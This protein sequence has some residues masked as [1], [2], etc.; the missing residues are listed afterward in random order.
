[1]ADNETERDESRMSE[2]FMSENEPSTFM[3]IVET[4]ED[5]SS[6]RDT[7]QRPRPGHGYGKHHRP[8]TYCLL[9]LF[10]LLFHS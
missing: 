5:A 6:T 4:D 2:S 9:A 7:F 8:C 1:M 3:P 10:Y